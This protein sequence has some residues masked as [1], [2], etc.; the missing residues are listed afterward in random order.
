MGPGRW[1][2]I[3]EEAKVVSNLSSSND[4]VSTQAISHTITHDTEPPRLEARPLHI[5]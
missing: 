5:R 3:H 2:T 4:N 1:K